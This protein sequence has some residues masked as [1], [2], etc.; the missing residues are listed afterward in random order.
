[1]SEINTNQIDEVSNFLTD[2]QKSIIKM[3]CTFDEKKFLEDK[4]KR[5]E[6]GGGLT[7]LLENGNIFDKV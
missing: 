2:L 5:E 4:W 3:I 6:G 7:C 1:M